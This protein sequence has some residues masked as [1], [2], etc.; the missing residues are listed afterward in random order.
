[1]DT[2]DIIGENGVQK[3]GSALFVKDGIIEKVWNNCANDAEFLVY[4]KTA[5]TNIK[6]IDV[7]GKILMPSFIDM[8]CH[9]RYPGQ[10]KKEDI[11]SCL[12]A[13]VTGGFGGIVAMPNTNPPVSNA[14]L[15][16]A[17][18]DKA[19]TLHMADVI[20]SIT[21]TR[22]FLGS[23][24]GH[25]DMLE[26]FPLV[27]ED[28]RDVESSAVMLE[29][30]EK[31][32][33]KGIIVGCHSEDA[34]LTIFAKILRSKAILLLQGYPAQEWVNL[35]CTNL[36]PNKAHTAKK[37]GGLDSVQ[38]CTQIDDSLKKANR[39]LAIAEDIATERNIALAALAN[40]KIHIDHIS[41]K[42]SIDTV[43]RW[44]KTIEN[45]STKP[46]VSL[47]CE[48]TPH[49]FA[50]TSDK[51]G[52]LRYIVNPP[53]RSE[54]DRQALVEALIDGTADVIAT[55]HAPHTAQD[56]ATGSPGF[57]GLETAFGATCTVLVHTKK[58]TF[59][60][61]SA[62]MSANPA[63]L[64]GLTKKG[65]LQTGYEASF[66]IADPDFAW[67][68][69]STHFKTKGKVCPFEGSQFIGKVL[70][71]WYKGKKVY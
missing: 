26:G 66:V 28:G 59:S 42:N 38:I 69:D 22:D 4:M 29:A 12:K 63:K 9:M 32:A 55:D 5:H 33:K 36:N 37:M 24:T 49:H 8:H 53:L 71:T 3:T 45:D 68:V 47:T 54:S 50:L 27:T 65:Q 10:S 21:I 62:L 70:Q 57:S 34:S 44:K 39:Y 58:I 43:R 60:Q 2:G 56:K 30:M 64:L 35:D 40:C 67:T 41:T 14:Q 18:Q 52:F 1:M 25:L 23:D 6:K 31:C 51:P 20:Q 15:A 13:A 19:K 11:K 46:A 7:A 17:I 16:K 61:L 48:I